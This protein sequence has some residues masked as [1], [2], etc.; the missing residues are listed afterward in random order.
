M[1]WSWIQSNSGT[2]SSG[3]SLTVSYTSNVSSGTKLI[4]AVSV[5]TTSGSSPV[6]SVQDAA[7][8]SMTQVGGALNSGNCWVGLYAMDTPAGDVG[9]QPAIKVSLSDNNGCSVLIQEVSGLLAGNTTAM[10]D[11]TAATNTGSSALTAPSGTYSTTAANEYLLAVFGDNGGPETVTKPSRFTTTDTHSVNANGSANC[12]AAYVNSSGG[13]GEGGTNAE[14]SMTGGP[15]WGNILVA[16]KLGSG[17]TSG[18]ALPQQYR[19]RRPAV[20]VSN[21]GWRGAQ[22]SR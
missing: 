14:W 9:T 21:A 3:A 8:N 22:H 10:V 16:F 15:Y 4:C 18:P 12:L 5:S 17:V 20:V 2:N 6:T 1:A 19:A 13:S 11:G 7:L